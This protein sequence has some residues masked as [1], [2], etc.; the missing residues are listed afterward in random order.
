MPN[1]WIWVLWRKLHTPFNIILHVW[2]MITL[3]ISLSPLHAT[4]TLLAYPAA[5]F[6]IEAL[7]YKYEMFLYRYI[8]SQTYNLEGWSVMAKWIGGGFGG[9]ICACI[10]GTSLAF[11]AGILAGW[12][13]CLIAV[14]KIYGFIAFCFSSK[15]AA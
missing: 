11:F 14:Y 5:W 10:Y 12:L 9:L 4:L 1:I 13:I 2:W 3:Y 15:N 6:I 7:G 8:D